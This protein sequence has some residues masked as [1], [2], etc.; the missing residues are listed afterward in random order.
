MKMLLA[1]ALLLSACAAVAQMSASA[2][3][4]PGSMRRT[5]RMRT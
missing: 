3:L 4:T 5:L 1:L 2:A